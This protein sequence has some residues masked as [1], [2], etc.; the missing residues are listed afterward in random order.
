MF[1]T[2]AVEFKFNQS[3]MREWQKFSRDRESILLYSE[4]LKFLN[5]EARV[6]ENTV[7]ESEHT[8]FS[9]SKARLK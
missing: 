5:L 2:A 9:L 4:L 1:I 8:A 6:A 3:T 7:G